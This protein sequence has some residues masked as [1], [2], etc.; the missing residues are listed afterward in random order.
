M[1]IVESAVM[2]DPL[3]Q[4]DIL[5]GLT[6]F[7]TQ[8]N[9]TSAAATKF[10]FCLV[11]SRPCVVA[12]KQQVVVVGVKAYSEGVPN[13]VDTFDKVVDFMTSA[14]D[15]VTSPDVFYL[16]QLPGE[17]GRFCA[18][19]DSFHTIEVPA[20][21]ADRTSYV[22]KHRVAT[23]NPEFQRAL[24][25]RLFGSFANMG[26][27][28]HAWPSDTDLEWIV[29]QGSADIKKLDGEVEQLKATKSSAVAAGKD[30]ASGQVSQ[31]ANMEK[32]LATLQERVAPYEEEM[33][34]RQQKTTPASNDG[35]LA[36]KK[37]QVTLEQIPST[38]EDR[39]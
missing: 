1:P 39:L 18:R 10:P 35:Q 14:R 33:K 17:A 12:H 2:G 34:K 6:L 28:D 38:D 5:R 9:G 21:S 37:A 11:V 29:T 26:F 8:V 13:A 23:L 30:L 15:G 24:H 16:G 25:S 36:V 7:I 32:K 3:N 4:G 20:A 31:L 22:D 27:D 19:F